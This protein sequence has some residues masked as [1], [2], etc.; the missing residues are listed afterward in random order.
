M[1]YIRPYRKGW[2]A[3]IEYKGVRDSKT[4]EKRVLAVAWGRRRE[5]EIDDGAKGILPH[6]LADA[7]DKYAKEVSPTKGGAR[8]EEIRLALFRR[9]M[10]G[11]VSKRIG[12]VCA[13]DIAEWRDERLRSIGKNR[14]QPITGE[15]VRREMTLLRS[16]FE[17]ARK[18]WGWI[19]VNPMQDIGWPP[20]GRSRT[21]R[22]TADEITRM[23]L[24]LGYE[25]GKPPVTKSQR[26]AVAFLLSC[27]TAMRA[28]ELCG[29]TTANVDL[30]ARVATL[31]QTKN[32]D[33]RQVPLTKEAVRL[34]QLLGDDMLALSAASLDA[35][36]RKAKKVAGVQDL[37]FHD[38]RAEGFT[39][40]SKKLDM[41]T[42]ARVGGHRDPRS[43]MIYY[44][45][46]AQDIAARL[47]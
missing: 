38:G 3:E 23:C 25:E 13:A 42:L 22:P 31:E 11:F 1:A 6:T 46:S 29:L 2:R 32:G 19:K 18:E 17:R 47:D 40:L 16:V 30:D 10:K 41:L 27:E 36:W 20:K 14:N 4:F 43:L 33:R 26:V 9:T 37:H 34:F 24:A 28:G 15:T 5:H 12:E 21:R 35:L 39:R 8:W 7:F 45:E 44:R